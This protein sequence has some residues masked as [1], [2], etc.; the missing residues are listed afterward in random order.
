MSITTELKIHACLRVEKV[1]ASVLL[2]GWQEQNSKPKPGWCDGEGGG[3]QKVFHFRA[4]PAHTASAR[5]R[6]VG[7][8][9]HGK[10]L[11][12]CLLHL[13]AMI[14]VFNRV[15]S[16]AEHASTGISLQV[17]FLKRPPDDFS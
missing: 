10:Y 13:D 1:F 16:A 3:S 7:V 15:K 12:S 5:V 9:R 17:V 11:Q 6:G 8:R 4:S 14:T 2:S